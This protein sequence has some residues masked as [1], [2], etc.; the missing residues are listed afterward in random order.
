MTRRVYVSEIEGG[1]VKGR[2][3]VERRD[4]M[5]EYALPSGSII[6]NEVHPGCSLP[7][8]LASIGKREKKGN[9]CTS[10]LEG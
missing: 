3:P 10:H 9:R 5:Q 8:C 6:T 7:L 2:P 1:N 4:R